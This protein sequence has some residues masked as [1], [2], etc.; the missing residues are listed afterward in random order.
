[1]RFDLGRLQS[2]DRSRLP[3][4]FATVRDKSDFLHA[5]VESWLDTSGVGS[6]CVVKTNSHPNWLLLNS[7]LLFKKNKNTKIKNQIITMID[8]ANK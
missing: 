5:W 2:W 7:L 1:M 8:E 4:R 6:S 3:T